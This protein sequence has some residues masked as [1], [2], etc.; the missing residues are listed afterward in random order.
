MSSLADHAEGA[1]RAAAFLAAHARGDTEG[2]TAL[3]GVFESDREMAAAFLTVAELA[4]QLHAAETGEQPEEFL[5][6]LTLH[7]AG[8][9]GTSR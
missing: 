8:A 2:A 4:V 5:R 9:V 6:D 3:L 7:L 1:Q